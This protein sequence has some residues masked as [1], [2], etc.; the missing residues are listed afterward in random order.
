MGVENDDLVNNAFIR[1][2]E[3]NLHRRHLFGNCQPCVQLVDVWHSWGLIQNGGFHVYFDEINERELKRVVKSYRAVG[4]DA[5]ASLI[6][7]AFDYFK[8]AKKSFGR[9]IMSYDDLR[10][11]RD[12][13]KFKL[14]KIEGEFY[15]SR[16][17]LVQILVSYINIHF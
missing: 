5:H 16:D 9:K 4:A 6:T 17:E 8:E 14:D 1:C 3:N 11:V 13:A 7:A 15:G 12:L 2:V 10:K